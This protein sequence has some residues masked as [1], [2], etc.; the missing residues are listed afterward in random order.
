MFWAFYRKSQEKSAGNQSNTD[1]PNLFGNE[2]M[3]HED[4]A[5]NDNVRNFF[6][7]RFANLMD[8]C[9][10]AF[11]VSYFFFFAIGGY[12][13]VSTHHCFLIVKLHKKYSDGSLFAK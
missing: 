4:L 12:L 2:S 9:V 10:P 7:V 13:H 5:W 11:I 8:Y 1:E 6:E 3:H